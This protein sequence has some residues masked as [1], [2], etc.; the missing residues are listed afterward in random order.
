MTPFRKAASAYKINVLITTLAQRGNQDMRTSEIPDRTIA[1][2]VNSDNT[3]EVGWPS[4]RI[5]SVKPWGNQGTRVSSTARNTNPVVR[6]ALQVNEER[7]QRYQPTITYS[8]TNPATHQRTGDPLTKVSTAASTSIRDRP[9][10]STAVS[11]GYFVLGTILMSAPAVLS[12][13]PY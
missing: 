11:A 7:R 9:T 10:V 2:I 5:P 12:T 1:A 6:R 8:A 13:D 4:K 3:R